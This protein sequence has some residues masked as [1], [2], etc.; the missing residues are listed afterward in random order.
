MV[1]TGSWSPTSGGTSGSSS[2]P[3]TWTAMGGAGGATTPTQTF[4]LQCGERR[5]ASIN[6]CPL[7]RLVVIGDY[8]WQGTAPGTLSGSSG[9]RLGSTHPHGSFAFPSRLKPFLSCSAGSGGASIDG[10]PLIGRERPGTLSGSSG[11]LLRNWAPPAR[12]A[13]PSRLKPPCRSQ[14]ECW[15]RRSSDKSTGG[16]GTA[17]GKLSGSSGRRLSLG[18]TRIAFPSRLKPP[19]PAAEAEC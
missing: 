14:A 6:W 7:D 1:T 16:Q 11:R 12:I 4:E 9:R 13:F 10:C 19:C 3:S 5:G 8:W 2:A 18:S 17:P 15:R